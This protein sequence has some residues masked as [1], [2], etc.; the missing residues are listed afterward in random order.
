MKEENYKSVYLWPQSR[1]SM[2]VNNMSLC[3]WEENCNRSQTL[4]ATKIPLPK[5]IVN[6]KS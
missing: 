1:T 3:K 2:F 4:L 5:I 6:M